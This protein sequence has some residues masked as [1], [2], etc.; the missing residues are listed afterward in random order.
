M[1]VPDASES[2]AS[3]A[4]TQL[5]ERNQKLIETLSPVPEE[6]VHC[7]SPKKI[8]SSYTDTQGCKKL[9][10]IFSLTAGVMVDDSSGVDIKVTNDGWELTLTEKWVDCHLEPEVCCTQFPRDHHNESDEDFERRKFAMMDT[11]RTLKSAGHDAAIL[12]A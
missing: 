10:V 2:I 1:P 11:V 12:T 7:W 6:E 5:P 4:F 9:A 3:R 8:V